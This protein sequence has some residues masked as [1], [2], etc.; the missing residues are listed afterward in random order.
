MKNE[1]IEIG[2]QHVAH[3]TFELGGQQKYKAHP[4]LIIGVK[5]VC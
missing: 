5:N 4:T 3:P 1:I 2:G